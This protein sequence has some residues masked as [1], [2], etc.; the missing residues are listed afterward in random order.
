MNISDKYKLIFF[1]LPKCAGKSVINALEI[2][3][4][5]K[6][7]IKTDLKQTTLLG[8]EQ[9]YWNQKIYPEKW[10][11]YKKFTIVRNPWDR[12]VS[13]YHYRK[14]ENDLYKLF[15]PAFGM[16]IMGGDRVGPDGKEWDFKRWILS[17][18]VKG[19]T[20]DKRASFDNEY[21]S[22]YKALKYDSKTLEEGIEYHRFFT[23]K[24][25]YIKLCSSEETISVGLDNSYGLFVYVRDRI[26]WWNQIDIISG[27]YGEKLIDY[28][29]RFEHLEEMWNKMFEEIGYEPPKLPKIGACKHKHYSEYYDDETRKFIGRLFEKDIKEFGYE[30]ERI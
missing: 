28:I 27:L 11:I 29:L 15:P 2:K 14:K 6:T 3:K 12:M 18:F 22:I 10:N 20:I 19:L 13:L 9:A 25:N 26:E 5:D 7:N 30:F 24:D 1:H 4:L 16:N 8:F 23:E 17:S 21:L